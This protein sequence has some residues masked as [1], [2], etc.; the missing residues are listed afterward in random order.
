MKLIRILFTSD[1]Y[2]RRYLFINPLAGFLEQ[3]SPIVCV[4]RRDLKSV[5]DVCSS[6]LK[7]ALLESDLKI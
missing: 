6:D 1:H 4:N 3:P 2:T 7:D 5:K